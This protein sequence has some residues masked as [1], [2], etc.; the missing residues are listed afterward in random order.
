V[1]KMSKVNWNEWLRGHT[2]EVLTEVGIQKGQTVLDFGCGSGLYSIPATH[3]VGK[4]GKVYA[5]DKNEEA[6][7][8]VAENTKKAGLGNVETICSDT[9]KTDLN[10]GSVDIVL[11]YDVIHLIEERTT[12]FSEVRRILKPE[13]VLSIYPMHVKT[14]EI[15]KQ[16]RENNFSLRD[17]KYEG[18]I[19]NFILSAG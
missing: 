19:L 1:V 14:D 5:L 12:L 6:L 17:E 18:N 11:L 15:K 2:E 7:K 8:R 16:M 9:L 13:G 4:E 3:L 10:D